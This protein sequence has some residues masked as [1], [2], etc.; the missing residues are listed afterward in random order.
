MSSFTA[1]FLLFFAACLIGLFALEYGLRLASPLQVQHFRFVYDPH[2]GFWHK[3]GLP[4]VNSFGMVDKPRPLERV[5]G[6]PRIAVLGDSYMEW[7]G[8]SGR[9][10]TD[11]IENSSGGR[12]EV[13]NFGISSVGTVQELDIYRHRVRQFKPDLVIVSLLTANDIRNNH[14]DLEM[15]SGY[16]FLRTAVRAR[17]KDGE[18]ELIAAPVPGWRERFRM[19]AY[20]QFP[21]LHDHLVY[22]LR[23]V[24][25]GDQEAYSRQYEQVT[26][27][28]YTPPGPGSAWDEAW[29]ITEATLLQMRS[30]V[31]A[32]GADFVL[33]ILSDAIQL[34]NDAELKERLG[35]DPPPNFDPF[36]PAT[37]LA[38]FCQE[39][40]MVC[41]NL[42][43]MFKEYRD[44]IGLEFPYFSHADDDHWAELGHSVAAEIVYDFIE[45]SYLCASC[46]WAPAG[47][48]RSPQW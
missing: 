20:D 41:I 14:F 19:A 34:F 21:A 31:E 8:L 35:G 43:P 17:L 25:T 4:E 11:L 37:R 1:K 39:T 16:Q 47:I 7:R 18:L 13:L 9:R 3:T 12:L 5:P 30:E 26:H 44:V 48:D 24:N 28:V 29:Q 42:A 27:G 15:S 40:G 6:K 22:A 46:E 45:R 10:M 2:P 38:E 33:V 23:S 32:D 36:Y